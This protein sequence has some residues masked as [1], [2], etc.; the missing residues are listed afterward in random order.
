MVREQSTFTFLEW[1]N[2]IKHKPESVKI[3][4]KLRILILNLYVQPWPDNTFLFQLLCKHLSWNKPPSPQFHVPNALSCLQM[5]F[6]FLLDHSLLT[7]SFSDWSVDF[8]S[9]LILFILF[10]DGGE[11][12]GRETSMCGCHS[13]APVYWGPGPQPRHVLWLGMEPVTL[14]FA[15]QCLIHWATPSRVISWFLNVN[16]MF[17]LSY[18]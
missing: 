5:D 16:R 13:H 9:F 11:E 8:F 12:R 4:K 3:N 2:M 18:V 10:L 1:P 7:C 15:D 14:W 17:T 6:P